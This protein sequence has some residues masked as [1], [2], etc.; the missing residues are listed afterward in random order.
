GNTLFPGW[1][2]DYLYL[3]VDFEC[4]FVEACLVPGLPAWILCNRAN[5]LYAIL[6]F[7]GYQHLGVGVSLVNH[8]IGR[9]QVAAFQRLMHYLD[10]VVI[11]RRCRSGFNIG[12]QMRSV[13]VAALRKMHLVANP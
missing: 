12:D 10:H 1:T 4:A 9:K 13:S 3:P 2:G 6:V 5:D 11:W 8:V 7:T